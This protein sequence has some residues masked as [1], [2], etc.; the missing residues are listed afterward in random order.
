[1]PATSRE[2]ARDGGSALL[3]SYRDGCALVL[4][5]AGTIALPLYCLAPQILELWVGAEFARTGAQTLR[6]MALYFAVWGSVVPMFNLVN[7]AGHASWNT[8]ATLCYGA[9]GLALCVL[10]VPVSGVEGAAHARVLALPAYLPILWAL[11]R[12]VLGGLG[13]GISLSALAWLGVMGGLALWLG[14]LTQA[15]IPA[16]WPAVL[17]AGIGLAVVGLGVALL[18]MGLGKALAQPA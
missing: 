7:G 17:G 2:V 13:W 15:A 5:L 11:H 12:F 4:V 9:T 3:R 16:A 10:M 6:I 8:A 1:L 18:A 14:S